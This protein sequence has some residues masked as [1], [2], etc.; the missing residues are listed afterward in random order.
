MDRVPEPELMDLPHEA[1]AYAA[2]DFSAVNAA[3]VDRLLELTDNLATVH[4]VDLGTG[5]G[6]IPT[7]VASARS[8]WKIDAV[9]AAPTMIDIAR[10]NESAARSRDVGRALTF[11]LAD[12][13]ATNLASASYNVVFS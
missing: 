12:A 8:G 3:F 2:A 1:A 4:A 13:T 7:R 10:R 9:D 6:E 5:P 11:H